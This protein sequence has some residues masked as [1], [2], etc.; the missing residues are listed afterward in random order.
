VSYDLDF[1]RYKPGTTLDHQEVYQ[2]L[3]DGRE[4]AGLET[5][6]ITDIRQAIADAF[7]QGWQQVGADSWESQTGAFQLYTTSQ[8]VRVDCYGMAGDDMNKIIDVLL[9]FNCPLYDP[10]V[11]ERFVVG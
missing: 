8:F 3:C 9:E 1:W 11:G 4:V 2:K 6:P 10:Q 7:A 5:L